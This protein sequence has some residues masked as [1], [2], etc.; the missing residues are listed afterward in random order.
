MHDSVISTSVRRAA[1]VA[2]A[3]ANQRSAGPAILSRSA[4]ARFPG[5]PWQPDL[6]V[7]PSSK[8]SPENVV[9]VS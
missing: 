4:V 6:D 2:F 7:E 8:R 1:P 3:T 9:P 5:T